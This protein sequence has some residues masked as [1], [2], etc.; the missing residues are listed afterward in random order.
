MSKSV[1]L[2]LSDIATKF[3]SNVS[4]PLHILVY[5]H[6]EDCCEHRPRKLVSS[7][8]EKS[9]EHVEVELHQVLPG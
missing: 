8:E 2:V 6:A 5:S 4:F 1:L 7:E 3:N 9:C